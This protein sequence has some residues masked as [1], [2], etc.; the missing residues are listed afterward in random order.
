[1]KFFGFNKNKPEDYNSGRDADSLRAFAL[2]K[3]KSEVNS[4]AK[5]KSSSSK[6]SGG[7]SSGSSSSGGKA[8][9]DRDVIVLT[10]ANFDQTIYGSKDIWMVEFYAPWC[11]HCKALEPEWNQA[12][13][14]MKGKVKFAKVDA[15]ENT[16][17]A[18]KFG[19]QGYPT[20]KYFDYGEKSSPRDAKPYEGAREAAGL[21]AFAS[22]LL[23]KADIEPDLW[24]LFNQKVYDGEC[25][26]TTI[27]IISF[28]PNI[29]ESSADER[30]TY[31]STIMQVAKS[32]RKYPFTFFWL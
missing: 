6:S 3:I 14:D 21:K 22:D 16:D 5:G 12:A 19:V 30:N 17:L 18:R 27:C 26:G 11:G 9:D 10:D 4:K 2:D 32:N 25:K 31:L 29:Y 15:T 13:A 23:D 1:L 28:L 7:S 24:E 20:I 8:T